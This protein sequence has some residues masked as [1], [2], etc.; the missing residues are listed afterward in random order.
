MVRRRLTVDKARARGRVG[1]VDLVDVVPRALVLFVVVCV[2]LW[3]VV[4]ALLLLGVFVG[5]VRGAVLVLA[6]RDYL[7]AGRVVVGE[8]VVV[9]FE[10]ARVVVDS[11]SLPESDGHVSVALDMI[12]ARRSLGQGATVGQMG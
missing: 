11:D 1:R 8:V 4:V 3:D 12:A 2:V 7:D 10:G 6:G 5:R 9:V